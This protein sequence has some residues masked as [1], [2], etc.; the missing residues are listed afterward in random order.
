M[1]KVLFALCCS[2]LLVTAANGQAVTPL[3]AS[4]LNHTNVRV[5]AVQMSGNWIW[6]GTDDA[7]KETTDE[8]VS[9]IDRAGAD[10]AD[11][12]VFP[13]LL[14][15]KFHVPNEIT[16]RI[17]E[18][19]ARNQIYVIAGCFE[20]IDAQG[21]YGNSAL[22][23]DRSGQIMG[24]YFKSHAALG[25]P[26]YMWPGRPDDPEELM[27][28]GSDFPVFDLDFGRI[29]IFTCYDG[30]FPEP[31]R[32]L[33]LKGAEILVWMNARNGAIEDY[34]VKTVMHQNYAHVVCTNKAFGSGTMIAEWPTRIENVLTE[35]KTGYLAADLPMSH[36]RDARK[37]A[38]EFYQRRPEIFHE[39]TQEH[40]VWSQYANLPDNPTI[41]AAWTEVQPMAVDTPLDYDESMPEGQDLSWL[42]VRMRAKWMDGW[43]TLRLPETLQSD[44]GTHFIDHKLSGLRQLSPLDPWP[45]WKHAKKTGEWR[46]EC[47]TREGLY[48]TAAARPYRDLVFLEFSAR[49]DTGKRLDFVDANP[50]FAMD[51]AT[52]FHQPWKLEPLFALV[53]GKW[54]S[55]AQTTPTPAVKGRP[56]WVVMVP[57]DAGSPFKGPNDSPTWWLLDQSADCNLM[58]AVSVDQKHLV[59]YA[60]DQSPRVLMSNTGHPCLHTGP[61][62]A[63]MLEPGMS[64]TRRGCVYFMEN[65][66]DQLLARYRADKANWD[67]WPVRPG[68]SS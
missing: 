3:A 45:Q 67:R 31:A 53:E 36:L 13:E 7:P 32:I 1:F 11:L 8:V 44:M 60:W 23:F 5:A 54:T 14:L 49:N 19:A 22:L 16:R 40:P 2:S 10:K 26:P 30:Y 6:Q 48:F 27:T 15:G 35:A 47:T 28:P 9:F 25:E 57:K 50:C 33:T 55:L 17:G 65:D 18:A 29:G 58:A 20:I 59:G 63:L 62:E 37:H 24:R 41:S 21:N 46:Y 38:R 51:E 61:G 56:P 12:V 4:Q 39:L 66:L 34:I 68:A 64:Y 43:I 42:A 52:D